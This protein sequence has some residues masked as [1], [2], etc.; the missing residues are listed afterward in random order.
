MYYF[1]VN[2]RS[3]GP[4]GMDS[5]STAN[6]S[7]P[8]LPS[9]GLSYQRTK[10]LIFPRKLESWSVALGARIRP[11]L[12]EGLTCTAISDLHNNEVLLLLH[13]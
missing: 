12:G 1:G 7:S 9:S 4:L 6:E 5:L 13:N 11:L 10:S 3:Q 2:H 8:A